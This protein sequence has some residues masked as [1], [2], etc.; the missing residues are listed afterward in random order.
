MRI[1]RSCV[2][3]FAIEAAVFLILNSAAVAQIGG[4]QNVTIVLDRGWQFRQVT[5]PS[6]PNAGWMP[7]TVPG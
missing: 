7:A 4:T 5:T 1:H 3:L 2:A 6:D